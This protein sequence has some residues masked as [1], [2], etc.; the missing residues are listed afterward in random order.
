MPSHCHCQSNGKLLLESGVYIFRDQKRRIM[1][2]NNQIN[3]KYRQ[4]NEGR[5]DCPNYY[6]T[7]GCFS[8]DRP[9]MVSENLV[10]HGS[11]KFDATII[12]SLIQR[13]LLHYDYQSNT[14]IHWI[15]WDKVSQYYNYKT[16]CKCKI[17]ILKIFI[18]RVALAK[19]G[20]N[21]VRSICSSVLQCALSR[22][23][24]SLGNIH[25]LSDGDQVKI[26]KSWIFS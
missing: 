19:Q 15:W 8:H 25:L 18:H 1:T 22:L 14:I 23:K 9:F 17:L 20:D 10:S 6:E 3:E 2:Q 21:R 7:F 24:K 5:Y 26:K 12:S 16:I 4:L 11:T 13:Q